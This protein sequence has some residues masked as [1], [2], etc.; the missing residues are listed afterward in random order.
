MVFDARP[1]WTS[2]FVRRALEDD[3]RFSVDY[4]ARV[5]PA[6]TA[7]TRNASFDTATLDEMS[8]VIVG[9]PDAL[10]SDDV[11]LLERYVRVR[12]GTVVLL[13]ERRSAGASAR[14][15][16]GPWTEHL[17][18]NSQPIGPLRASEI[19]RMTNVPSAA[20][21]VARSGTA[22]RN[23]ESA[24]RERPRHRLR[25]DGRM[26]ISSS[27][28]GLFDDAR[29]EPLDVAR[30][31]RVRFVLAIARGPRRLGWRRTVAF[32]R[33]ID[34][35]SSVRASESR[36]A[37]VISICDPRLKRAPS[38]DAMTAPPL[39]CACGRPARVGE[40]EGEVPAAEVGGCLVEATVGE[41]EDR[42]GRDGRA[43]AAGVERHTREPRHAVRASG[44]VVTRSGSGRRRHYSDRVQA[45]GVI[46]CL[47]SSDACLVVDVSVRRVSY[48]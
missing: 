28:C 18:A 46:R 11:T 7:G 48:C 16:Q 42:R 29:G 24:G 8:A 34:R 12:G 25:C 19:L 23:R 6:L 39:S 31:K 40:F 1:S 3:G 44:G 4:R 38:F 21:V 43:S 26:A 2:T 30:D 32:I 41:R 22:A 37:T 15:F 5:A 47:R 36:F 27:R 20:T 33:A 9:G 17:T 13:P 10:T 14:L 35:A 45:K